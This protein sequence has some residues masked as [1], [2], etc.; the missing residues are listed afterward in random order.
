MKKVLIIGNGFDL[1]LG[2]KTGYNHFIESD[3]FKKLLSDDSNLANHLKNISD[4]NDWVDIELELST[5]SDKNHDFTLFKSEYRNLC[6]ELT[7]YLN[8]LNFKVVDEKSEAYLFLTS[9]VLKGSDIDDFVIFDFNYTPTSRNILQKIGIPDEE[10]KKRLIKIHGTTDANNIIFGIH[11]Q[12]GVS[13][14]KNLIKKS[15][16]P[17]FNESNINKIMEKCSEISIFGHSLGKTDEIYFKPIFYNYS[18]TSGDQIKLNLYHHGD[19]AHDSFYDRLADLTGNQIAR[20]RKKINIKL[21]NT[22]KDS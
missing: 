2:F 9:N 18:V 13:P 4:K 7:N 19:D 10:I 11:D 20:F 15:T 22:K 21:K 5:Y 12:A 8:S 14:I 16:K 6:S 3:N 1:N 17:N